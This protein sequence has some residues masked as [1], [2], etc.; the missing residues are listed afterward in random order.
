[1][2]KFVFGSGDILRDIKEYRA[3]TAAFRN[4]E[5]PPDHRGQILNISDDRT[6]FGNGHGDARDIHLLEAVLSEQGDADVA[7]KCHDR[8]RVHIS[9][10]NAC[11]Q[12]CSSGAGCGKHNAGLTGCPGIAVSR[13][14]RALLMGRQDVT[15]FVLMMVKRIIDIEDRTPGITENRIHSLFLQA[16]YEDFRTI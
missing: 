7:G 14:G 12:V 10:R 6:V 15:D 2:G 4:T 9:G 8:Y 11:D 13:V 1:M 16:F 3:G 5:R